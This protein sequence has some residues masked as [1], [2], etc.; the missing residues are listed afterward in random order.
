M[1]EDS[2]NSEKSGK[3]FKKKKSQWI[4]DWTIIWNEWQIYTKVNALLRG[5]LYWSLYIS[6]VE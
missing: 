1:M 2:F 6:A 4:L 3:I 5:N